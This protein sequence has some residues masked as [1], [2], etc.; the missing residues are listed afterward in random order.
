MPKSRLPLSDRKRGSIQEIVDPVALAT[1]DLLKQ[2]LPDRSKAVIV[3]SFQM[4]IGTML[5]IMVDSGR[6]GHWSRYS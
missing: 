5:Y 3:W 1:I 4:I 6:A 2:T